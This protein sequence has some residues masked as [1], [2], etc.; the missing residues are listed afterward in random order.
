MEFDG[1]SNDSSSMNDTCPEIQLVPPSIFIQPISFEPHERF[2]NL[3]QSN[4]D[5]ESAVISN[6][7]EY[8]AENK[9]EERSTNKGVEVCYDSHVIKKKAAKTVISCWQQVKRGMDIDMK[10]DIFKLLLQHPSFMNILSFATSTVERSILSNIQN[11]MQ[12]VKVSQSAIEL[13][14]KRSTCLMILNGNSS[15][16]VNHTQIANFLGLHR[17]N[18]VATSARLQVSEDG[19]LSLELC[20]K[21]P[22][23]SHVITDQMKDLVLAF[24][25]SQTRVSPNKKD[26]CR[27]RVGRGSF[28]E[29]AI[30]LLDEP[31]FISSGAAF[32]VANNNTDV[33]KMFAA[34]EERLDGD[35]YPMWAYMMQHVLVSKGIWNIVQ[36]IDVRPDSVDVGEVEDVAG[37][38]AR[39][40]VAKFVL[41]T[42]EQAHWDVKDVQAHALIALSVKHTITPHIRSAK[43]AKQ[44]RDILAGL[45]AGRYAGRNEAKIALLRKELESKIMNE[46]DDIITFLV[47]VKDINEKLIFAGEII[48]NNSLVLTILYALPDSY[49]TFAS[50][51]Q[52]MNQRNLEVVKF[53]EVY[54]LLLREALSKKNRDARE[55]HNEDYGNEY[56]PPL[57]TQE[58]LRKM[59]HCRLVGEAT[60][61]MLNFAKD[62]NLAKY[63]TE[64]TFQDV[65]AQWK[66][67]TTSPP[68]PKKQYLEKELAEKV[69]AR[70]AQIFDAHKKGKKHDKKRRK[71]IDFPGYLGCQSTFNK[72]KKHKKRV[73]FARVPSSFSSSSESSSDSSEEDRKGKK[74]SK[75]QRHRKS[76]KKARKSKS[77]RVEYSSTT[78]DTSTDSSDS[79]DGHFY[80]NKKNFYKTNQY[81]F[82]E[83]KSK[84]VRKAPFKIVEGAMKVP[85]FI[86][87]KDKIFEADEYT[88]DLDT[89]FAKVRETLRETLQNSQERQK[90][91]ADRNRC[92]LKLKENDWVLLRFEKARLRKKKG[93]RK[94][95]FPNLSM[96]YYRPF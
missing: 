49:Q 40:A 39:I 9:R 5:I 77:R 54:T 4:K 24:W 36:G 55:D 38:A 41:P 6:I 3:Q 26:V 51:W 31:Q 92:D 88:R 23:V 44:A 65:H 1:C 18:L 63:M 27:K 2:H 60:N 46:E 94:R 58:D 72:A 20:Q 10:K 17:R 82:L 81:D 19:E 74:R 33:F 64:T 8:W 21:Q 76:K 62:P 16:R 22:K 30:H 71:G 14:L 86:S 56:G 25:T 84:K 87:T 79:E 48:S 47:G 80:A 37:P 89:D 69:E 52:L 59:Q 83:D 43:S 68:K 90:K 7:R 73:R 96:R 67:T 50:T 91:A 34:A 13:A 42:V 53:D 61:M 28:T 12:Q 70:L 57:P 32:T 93:E 66:A 85:P 95:L 45:Y 29:Y 35:N 78:E 75:K 11:T 15:T